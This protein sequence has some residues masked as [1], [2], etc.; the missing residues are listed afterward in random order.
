MLEVSRRSP[1]Y[2]QSIQFPEAQPSIASA[3][4]KAPPSQ[5]ATTLAEKKV[6][7][8][9]TLLADYAEE[10]NKKASTSRKLTVLSITIAAIFLIATLA[11]VFFAPPTILF[12][13]PYAIFYISLGVSFANFFD[14]DDFA[15][16]AD[17]V[18]NLTQN[19]FYKEKL[20][21]LTVNS[22]KDAEFILSDISRLLEL[23]QTLKALKE[24][25]KGPNNESSRARKQELIEEQERALDGAKAAFIKS[26]EGNAKLGDG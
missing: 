10:M 4:I 12:I 9:D 19:P 13:V 24:Q 17:S 20:K 1:N 6:K 18:K 22:T 8:V 5:A 2:H 14:S 16:R 21:D 11:I 26:L 7:T 25:L 23:E 3:L 15:D